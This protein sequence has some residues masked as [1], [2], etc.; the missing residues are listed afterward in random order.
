M[1][2][3]LKW[4]RKQKQLRELE[5]V[6]GIDKYRERIIA[7]FLASQQGQQPA[8]V[9]MQPT[10]QATPRPAVPPS[11]ANGGIGAAAASEPTSDEL[12]LDGFFAEARKPRKR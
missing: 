7:E 4:H 2:E 10:R 11:L 5:E 1:G 12:D 8:S 9:N 3:V 6:G